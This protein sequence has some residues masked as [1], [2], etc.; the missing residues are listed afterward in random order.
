MPWSMIASVEFNIIHV[1]FGLLSLIAKCGAPNP[2]LY[3][4]QLVSSLEGNEELPIVILQIN[5]KFIY[6][7]AYLL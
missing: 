2:V 7:E 4:I 6:R 1:K 5:S 3:D